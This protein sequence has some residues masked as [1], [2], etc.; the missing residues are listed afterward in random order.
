MRQA[1][2]AVVLEQLQPLAGAD[3][4]VPLLLRVVRRRMSL[5]KGVLLAGAAKPLDAALISLLLSA[6]HISLRTCTPPQ[7]RSSGP[8]HG[9]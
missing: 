6:E 1:S 9:G 3:V 4:P 7:R 8:A 2:G 5:R